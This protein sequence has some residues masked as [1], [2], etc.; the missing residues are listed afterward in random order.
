MIIRLRRM[1]VKKF[2]FGVAAA[3]ALGL[4]ALSV[5]ASAATALPATSA[6]AAPMTD[7][8]A[9][10]YIERRRMIRRGPVCT[11]RTEV[12]RG[13]YGRRVVTKT[14]VCR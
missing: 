9:Q 7:I 6:V 14:R 4:G 13:P 8:S 10:R 3:I 2:A 11:V 12:R 5:P 1:L